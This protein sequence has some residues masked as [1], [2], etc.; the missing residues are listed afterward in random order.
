MEGIEGRGDARQ[1]V[2]VGTRIRRRCTA[3]EKFRI[4]REAQKSEAVRQ[5][6]APRHGVP[7]T[8]SDRRRGAGSGGS[9]M[10]RRDCY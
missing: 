8:I 6:V 1:A 3:K 9:G 4:V 5:E 7:I 10:K 2:G